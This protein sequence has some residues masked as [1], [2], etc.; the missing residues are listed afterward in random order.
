MDELLDIPDSPERDYVVKKLWEVVK[1]MAEDDPT[2]YDHFDPE[3]RD[4][5]REFV[6]TGVLGRRR[7]LP[8]TGGLG[9]SLAILLIGFALIGTGIRISRKERRHTSR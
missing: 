1:K 8:K 7:S 3:M 9:G 4:I 5:L 2:F 6:R